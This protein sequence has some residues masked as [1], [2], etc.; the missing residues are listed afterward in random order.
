MFDFSSSPT[1]S[2]VNLQ[3]SPNLN[4]ENS[5]INLTI[6]KSTDGNP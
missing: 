4:Q 3:R 6:N 1:S 5:K 2:A